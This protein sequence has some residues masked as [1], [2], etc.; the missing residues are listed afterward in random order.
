MTLVC[1]QAAGGFVPRVLK[2][3]W[4]FFFYKRKGCHKGPLYSLLLIHLFYI[5]NPLCRG[6]LDSKQLAWLCSI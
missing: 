4:I 5:Q 3:E 1:S 2:I 6:L